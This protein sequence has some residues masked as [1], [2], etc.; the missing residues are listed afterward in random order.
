MNAVI[1]A[2][3]RT[4][5]SEALGGAL[6]HSLWQGAIAAGFLSLFRSARTRYVAGC[7]ALVA[8][9][10][11]F[12][13]TFWTL[14]PEG[15]I[16]AGAREF[17]I[18]GRASTGASAT[19]AGTILRVGD[20]LAWLTPLWFAGV[21]LFQLRTLMGWMAA[22]RLRLRGVCAAPEQWSSTLEEL[23]ARMRVSRPVQLLESSLAE[24]PVLVGYL[25]P[26]ILVPAGLLSSMPPQHVELILLHELAHI[27]RHDYLVNLLQ[28]V[29][30]GLFFYHPAVWWISGVVRAEREH[31]CDDLAVA[32]SS[33]GEAYEY[34]V[35]LTALEQSRWGTN[36][37]LER[38][39][40]VA[41]TGGKLMARIHRLLYPKRPAAL[42]AGVP[43]LGVVLAVLAAWHSAAAPQ[44]PNENADPYMKWV[45]EDVVYIIDEEEREAYLRLDTD[46]ERDHFVGQ[47]WER[48]DPTPGTPRNEVREEHYRRIA[49]ANDRYGSPS[50]AGWGT[51]RGRVYI[52][53]GPPDEIESHPS[54]RGE[55]PPFEMW[56]YKD[57]E[58]VGEEVIVEFVDA[59]RNGEYRLI[60]DP[61]KRN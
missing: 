30:E 20:V 13:F 7:V 58:G 17:S 32:A 9:L 54:G 22:R 51:D 53:Y 39:A 2:V 10:G 5:L 21:V 42:S 31:C 45:N 50:R 36:D 12:V 61:S 43:L 25:R 29:T 56:R 23:A 33:S 34:A 19:A 11:G 24:V 35:A 41:A 1:E 46:A 4:P 60:A 40:G 16:A 6:F 3:V 26:V 49:W 8:I 47:F 15:G 55:R 48:R 28:T 44:S 37:Q 14:L 52:T 27:R 38:A 59:Y 57:L 18:S